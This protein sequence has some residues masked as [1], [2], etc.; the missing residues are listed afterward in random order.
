MSYRRVFTGRISHV[1]N[2]FEELTAF[3]MR[4][5]NQFGRF[6]SPTKTVEDSTWV[7]H[8]IR[9]S[10]FTFCEEYNA[11]IETIICIR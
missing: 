1:P 8:L 5:L 10:H 3:G 4:R 7:R 2:L 11:I 9:T 6:K